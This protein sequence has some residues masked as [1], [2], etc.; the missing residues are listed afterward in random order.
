MKYHV[1]EEMEAAAFQQKCYTQYRNR[2]SAE[3]E[4]LL[5]GD[6]KLPHCYWHYLLH[7][8]TRIR[9]AH[10]VCVLRLTF[11]GKIEAS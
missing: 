5:L 7:T 9:G 10:T 1:C 8:D 11:V 2:H 4:A 3:G 6:V